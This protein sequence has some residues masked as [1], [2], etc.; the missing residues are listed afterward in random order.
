MAADRARKVRLFARRLEQ[1]FG[2]RFEVSYDTGARWQLDWV[3][4]PGEPAVRA[5]A[6]A[7]DL[8]GA[9]L[10]LYRRYST[11]AIAV[12]AIRMKTAGKLG[13]HDGGR[14]PQ[15]IVEWEAL[16]LDH[17]DRGTDALQDALAELLVATAIAKAKTARADWEATRPQRWVPGGSPVPLDAT[18]TAVD[19]I[20]TRGVGWLVEQVIA[21]GATVPPLVVLSARYAAHAD[22]GAAV[23]WAHRAQPLPLHT[24]VAL[25]LADDD[26]PAAAGA[27]LLALL[28]DLRAEWAR[29]EAAITAAARRA[30][31]PEPAPR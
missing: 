8:A 24:A 4:G 22:A 5:L 26:P 30:G 20:R 27:A 29:T 3:D 28:P 31:P 11:K 12:T 21:N 15:E 2:G 23:A 25:A 19:L 9:D 7:A 10:R 13:R 14:H 6:A 17:P 1:R 18:E 16:D